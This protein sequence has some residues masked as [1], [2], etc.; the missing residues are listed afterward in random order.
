MTMVLVAFFG[1]FDI[2][3]FVLVSDFELRAF[4]TTE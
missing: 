4:G 2:R 3:S 1:H